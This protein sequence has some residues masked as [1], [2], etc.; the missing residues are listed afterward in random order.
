MF[1]AKQQV[2]HAGGNYKEAEYCNRTKG[3]MYGPSP[4][5]VGILAI[6]VLM[7]LW[8]VVKGSVR[9]GELVFLGLLGMIFLI[10]WV[11]DLIPPNAIMGL[12]SFWPAVSSGGVRRR[13]RET[14]RGVRSQDC[15]GLEQERTTGS[16]Y[17][18]AAFT[19][20]PPCRQPV[21]GS[22]YRSIPLQQP[23]TAQRLA[24]SALRH[25]GEGTGYWS[26]HDRDK[27]GIACEPW[28]R[29]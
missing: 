9:I 20:A 22:R 12:L 27:D 26:R 17:Q 5:A 19:L 23:L 10:N 29:R 16:R 13:R 3:I 15:G 11:G 21:T 25:P 28:P 8:R 7:V 2:P 6:G 18:T 24:R 4:L 14:G 1:G